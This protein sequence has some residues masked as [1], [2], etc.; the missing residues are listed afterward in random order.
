[1]ACAGGAYSQTNPTGQFFNPADNSLTNPMGMS[2]L[3]N[4]TYANLNLYPYMA[5]L[6]NGLVMMIAGRLTRFYK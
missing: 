2:I 4:V 3:Q 6:P 1:M 5:L